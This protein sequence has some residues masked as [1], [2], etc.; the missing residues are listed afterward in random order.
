MI[1]KL[2]S[3]LLVFC[4]TLGFSFSASAA[5]APSVSIDGQKIGFTSSSGSP[6]LDSSSRTL[7]PLRIAMETYGC[8]VYWDN[9]NQNA[10]VYKDGITVV[11][12]IDKSY[13]EVNGER[14]AIDTAAVVRSGRTYLPIRCVLEAMGAT[15]G[16]DGASG[17]VLVTRGETGVSRG[18]DE[19]IDR[20]VAAIDANNKLA[21]EEAIEIRAVARHFLK[22]LPV[23]EAQIGKICTRL[24]NLDFKVHESGCAGESIRH[25]KDTYTISLLR[26]LWDSALYWR[27]NI[28]P[29]GVDSTLA[30][31][32]NHVF[33]E[34]TGTEWFQEGMVSILNHEIS[35][36]YNTA[37]Y[38][39]YERICFLLL[40]ICGMD[41]VLACYFTGDETPLCNM[42]DQYA[43]V[44]NSKTLLKSLAPILQNSF[45]NGYYAGSEADKQAYLKA[46][47]EITELFEKAYEGKYGASIHENALCQVY[48]TWLNT[49]GSLFII[50]PE[51]DFT[52]SPETPP[53]YYNLENYHSVIIIKDANRLMS[54]DGEFM[55]YRR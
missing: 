9:E 18:Q 34:Q 25:D 6:F 36:K 8:K 13:I 10:I 45:E 20:A 38:Q 7:V 29:D 19:Y 41:E 46:A 42:L 11:C 49:W 31:E 26:A 16:W 1:K 55:Y 50:K 14:V 24:G 47:A 51:G 3:T 4:L 12:P 5:P 48:L 2:I 22:T 52:C 30:H 15:V 43:G 35:A 21:E 23:T 28:A 44:R 32:L 54:E 53:F 39:G 33:S 40:E 27:S 17:T 37:N